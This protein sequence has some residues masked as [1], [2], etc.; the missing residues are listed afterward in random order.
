MELKFSKSKQIGNK[1]QKS[2]IKDK[3]IKTII[4]AL[5]DLFCYTHDEFFY[6]KCMRCGRRMPANVANLSHI[7]KRSRRPDLK[8]DLNNL[9][10][11]CPDCHQKQEKTGT[12]YRPESFKGWLKIKGVI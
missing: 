8:Y 12:D 6:V 11:L 2:Y 3:G 9:Q 1:K 7:A 5:W 4:L 10:I